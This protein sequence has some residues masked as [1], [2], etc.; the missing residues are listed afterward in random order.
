MLFF[1]ASDE[2]K[3][4]DVHQIHKLHHPKLS[5]NPKVKN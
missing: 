5:Q 2:D 3:I 4:N 1:D